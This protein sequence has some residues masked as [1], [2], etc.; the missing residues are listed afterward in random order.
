M[1]DRSDV[2]L[3]SLLLVA[4]KGNNAGENERGSYPFLHTS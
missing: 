4:A 1:Q 2:A 3:L